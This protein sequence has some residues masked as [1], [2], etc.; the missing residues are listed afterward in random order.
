M[1]HKKTRLNKF[2]NDRVEYY[3]KEGL[4]PKTAN[5]MAKYDLRDLVHSPSLI[6]KIMLEK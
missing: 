4:S 5:Q 1:V 2:F 3:L 6:K